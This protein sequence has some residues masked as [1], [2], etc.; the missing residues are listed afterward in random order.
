MTEAQYFHLCEKYIEG[1]CSTEEEL[2]LISYQQTH[3]V[4]DFD[5]SIHENLVL[6]DEIKSKLLQSIQPKK[7]RIFSNYSF[8][9][10]IAASFTIAFML[11][12][13]FAY[14]YF[15]NSEGGISLSKAKKNSK[16][17][18]DIQP[19]TNKAILTLA[20]GT[21]IELDETQNGLLSSNG[22][23]NISKSADGLVIS[24]N[25]A[26]KNVSKSVL[27][28]IDIPRGGKYNIALPDGSHVWLN[29]SSSLSFP[30]VFGANERKVLLTGEAY[31][32]VAKNKNKPFK[33]DVAGKQTVEV[34]GTHFNV[35]AFENNIE[36]T[37]LEGA[38]KV[39]YASIDA[40]LKPGQMSINNL[41]G[42]LNVVPAN[43]DEVMAW[44]NNMFIFNNENITSIM[45]KISRWYDVDVDFKGNMAA[46]N[47]DGN[48]SSEKGLKSLLKNLELTDKVRF[49]VV[50]R[51]VTVIAK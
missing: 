46:I 44:K 14:R 47:F 41:Q 51:R 27:N 13:Y 31:F 5:T 25:G 10:K 37:L 15:D 32:E 18:D 50:E 39:K 11:S 21:K 9:W 7:K 33:V 8:N 3:G 1:L 36:T 49:L 30:S 2:Q 19:A 23:T 22:N 24:S 48:F 34:L 17:I 43:L 20:D 35:N 29:S 42:K 40:L 6:R 38:V 16:Q 28:K 45:N 4:A 26:D 12:G